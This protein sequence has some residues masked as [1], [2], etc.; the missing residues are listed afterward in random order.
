MMIGGF[1]GGFV[2]GALVGAGTALL[3]AP[4]SGAEVRQGIQDKMAELQGNVEHTMSEAQARAQHVTDEVQERAAE[5]A[6]RGN[7]ALRQGER[8]V[9]QA[10][11]ETRGAAR[12]LKHN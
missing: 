1:V 10:V 7:A 11:D 5:L 2:V 3:T 6:S 12:D 8:K 4:R 9:Q